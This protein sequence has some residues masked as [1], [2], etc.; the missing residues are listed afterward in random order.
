M[1][2]GFSIITDRLKGELGLDRIYCNELVFEDGLLTG[3][4]MNVTSDKGCGNTGNK[5]VGN[6][7]K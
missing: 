5:G 7:E 3:L 4:K 6:S 1:S 2:G